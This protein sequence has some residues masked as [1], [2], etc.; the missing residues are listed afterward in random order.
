MK[1][2]EDIEKEFN[3][4]KKTYIGQ[5]LLRT[6]HY[7]LTVPNV[8]YDWKKGIQLLRHV[9]SRKRSCLFQGQKTEKKQPSDREEEDVADVLCA[10][11]F[12]RQYSRHISLGCTLSRIT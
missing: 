7:G 5:H 9:K 8:S 11:S 2:P 4:L 3:N 12:P 10:G 6:I 1:P